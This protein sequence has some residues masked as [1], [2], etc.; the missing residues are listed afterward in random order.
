MNQI[1]GHRS[2]LALYAVCAGVLMVLVDVSIV[3]VALPSIA[4]DLQL[5]STSL[6]W[7]LNA[8]ALTFAGCLPLAG[9][10]GDLYSPRRVFLTGIVL[11]TLASLA[12]GLAYSETTLILARAAQGIGG[13]ATTAVS[14]VIINNLF[15]LPAERA[16]AI[17]I[18]G[19]VSLSGG[20]LGEIS[21][22]FLSQLLSWHWIFFVNLPIG[23]GVC[24][25]CFTFLPNDI[26]PCK[27]RSL[28][29]SGATLVAAVSSL[30]IYSLTQ[31]TK[32]GWASIQTLA[33]LALSYVCLRFLIII[34]RRT[35]EPILPLSVFKRPN[36]ATTM[37]IGLLWLA[38]SSSWG[39]IAVLYLQRV[40]GYTPIQVGLAFAPTTA[41][42]ASLS[43]IFAKIVTQLGIR[44]SLW[45]GLLTS[46]A[47]MALF[48][49]VPLAGTFSV[50]VLP[51][52]ALLTIGGGMASISLPLAAIG[53]VS[54][55]DRGL[56]SSLLTTSFM[57][58]GAFGLAVFGSLADARTSELQKSGASL[59]VAL[60]GGYQLAILAGGLLVVV[61]AALSK[62]CLRSTTERHLTKNTAIDTPT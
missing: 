32:S 17:A 50:D 11:F 37:L 5:S 45:V 40:L 4:T 8:Y 28:D 2:S 60:D 58:G 43:L 22:G 39:L 9:R 44:K 12:C 19:L 16:K 29:L 15:A 23:I 42:G 41:I 33:P 35:P 56:A 7:V 20:A 14:L 31:S 3:T 48:A 55:E 27:R 59:I 6:T 57:L 30:T 24:L 18:Y 46:A 62:F 26:L 49:R 54:S 21:G 34:E 25:L 47:G 61:A 36:F 52:L 13:A 1:H 51:A 38:G 53:A 10:L